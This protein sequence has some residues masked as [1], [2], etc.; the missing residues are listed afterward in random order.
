MKKLIPAFA[1]LFFATGAFAQTEKDRSMKPIMDDC[2][3]LI[4]IS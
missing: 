4:I 3:T 2:K 1:L